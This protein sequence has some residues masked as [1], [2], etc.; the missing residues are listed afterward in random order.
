MFKS[1]KGKLITLMTLL[2]MSI[3]F[4]GL[5]YINNLNR[6]N[7]VSTDIT[8][9]YIPGIIESGNMNTMTSDYRILEYEHIIST[10]INEMSQKEKQMEDKNNEIS[11]EMALYEKSFYSSEDKK[12]FESF[13]NDWNEYLKLHQNVIKLSSELKTDEAMKIMNGDSKKLFDTA[14]ASLLKLVEYNQKI[15]DDYSKQGDETYLRVRYISIIAI[16]AITLISIIVSFIIIK[17]I[18]E[19]LNTLRKELDELAERGGDLTQDIKVKSKDE[20]AGLANSLNKFLSNLR[21]IIKGVNDSTENVISINNDINNKI[22]ELAKSIEEVS[23]NTENIA[24]GMEETAASSEEML[25]TSHEIEKAVT[26]MAEKIQDG[27]IS[28]EGIQ[29]SADDVKK[30]TVKSQKGAEDIFMETQNSLG[31]AI[32][33]SQVVARISIL[34]ESIIEI[35]AQTDLLAL[36]AAIEAARAGEAGK[37]FAVVAEEVR[38]LAEE[39]KNIVV[40][41][42]NVT[43]KVTESVKDLSDNSSRLLKYISTNVNDDYK[44]MIQVSNKYNDDAQFVNNL[45]TDFSA[46]SEELLASIQ[47]I[48]KTIDQVTEASTD[49]AEG[50]TEIAA[51]V[52]DIKEKTSMVISNIQN[53]KESTNKL[54]SEISKFKF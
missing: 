39:S 47:D 23:A 26:G 29:K 37:G 15:S 1:I 30:Q 7:Q 13:K 24:A 50:T 34:S 51:K 53:S 54:I 40:E 32:E 6:V 42:N 31:K 43:Q 52:I 38:K 3:V 21:Y 12:L 19:S 28:V 22:D 16:I 8:E 33:N 46:T 11:K 41:I 5:Y 35:A 49:G 27:L 18:V 4:L 25:A 9:D 20:I 48:L 14:S 2:I 44:S 17:Q 10:D 45:V 36:N